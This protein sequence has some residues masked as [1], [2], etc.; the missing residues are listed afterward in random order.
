MEVGECKSVHIMQ[1][2]AQS[3]SNAWGKKQAGQQWGN[4]GQE[5]RVKFGEELI[6]A[7]WCFLVRAL[8]RPLFARNFLLKVCSQLKCQSLGDILSLIYLAF[9]RH[10]NPAR[11]EKKWQERRP[12][13][14]AGNYILGV[15]ASINIV[16]GFMKYKYIYTIWLTL[17][18]IIRIYKFKQKYGHTLADTFLEHNVHS[19]SCLLWWLSI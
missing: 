11:R 8:L 12:W 13:G 3:S 19:L 17:I 2:N 5:T 6:A 14:A 16:W 9:C 10:D 7:R 1:C 15:L 4:E 18:N